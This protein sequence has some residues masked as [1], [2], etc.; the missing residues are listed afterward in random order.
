MKISY[1]RQYFAKEVNII[2]VGCNQTIIGEGERERG[3][4]KRK[5]RENRRGGED[6][7]REIE[8]GEELD[9]R[10]QNL[11]EREGISL[12]HYQKLSELHCII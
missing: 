5:K 4:K 2:D 12:F 1:Y 9:K 10:K 6:T 7:R 11:R 8:S 3:V